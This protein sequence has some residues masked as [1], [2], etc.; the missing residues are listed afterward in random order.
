GAAAVG[1]AC[2]LPLLREAFEAMAQDA[3]VT[4]APHK[5]L[6]MVVD[7]NKCQLDAV[8]RAAVEA[9]DRAHNIPHIP[10][11]K[12]EVKWIWSAEYQHAFPDQVH[13]HTPESQLREPVL[14]MCNHCSDPPCVRVC[15]TQATFKRKSDGIVVIDEHR[16]IGCRYC[17]AACPFGAR[18]LNWVDPRPYI[19]RKEDGE[20]YSDFPTRTQGVVEKCD[21][22]V[23]RLR[24]GQLPACVEAA[25]GVEGGAGALTFGDVL[26]PD[27]DVSRLLRER[28]TIVRR[29]ELGT[30]PNI[31]YV[32]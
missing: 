28:T 22:C 1:L 5:Q 10:D 12:H 4:P 20:Y 21:F 9:C 16:C 8:R 11:P 3:V 18:S 25:A 19:P 31:Y 7:V 27:S 17:M 23:E 29:P 15:P 32:T 2:S 30:G 13:L 6:A 14:V 26:D 24:V